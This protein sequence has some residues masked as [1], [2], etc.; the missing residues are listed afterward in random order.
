MPL[1][2]FEPRYRRLLRDCLDRD[3]MFGL[4]YRPA[5]IDDR[6]LTA[7]TVGCRANIDDVE[8]LTDG[9][10]NIIV[11]GGDRFAFV[12]ILDDD[13]PY[14]VAEVETFV[15]DREPI[16]QLTAL[17]LRLRELFA[18]AARAARALA[19]EPIGAPELPDD[20]ASV[21]F[22]AAASIDLELPHRQRLLSSPSPS[23]R[24]RDLIT[25]LDGSLPALA[26]RA[27]VHGRAKLNGH[28]PRLSA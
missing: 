19:D 16:A 24:M 26:S 6:A 3:R 7:G 4:I 18:E 9:R 27:A 21:A 23:A 12:R 22:A 17:S 11:R 13:A 28:G 1:R 10:A 25:V 14:Y 15:D 8:P 20:P 5:D 2:I